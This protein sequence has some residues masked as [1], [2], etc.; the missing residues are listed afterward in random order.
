M[1]QQDKEQLKLEIDHIFE[2]GANEIRIFEMVV[3]F[4][5]SRNGVNKNFVLADVVGMQ[6][7]G[8][9]TLKNKYMLE[10]LEEQLQDYLEQKKAIEAECIQLMK[11]GK[12]WKKLAKKGAGLKMMIEA[13]LLEIKRLS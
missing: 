13:T 10:L 7:Y 9:E 12:E 8:I 11:E 6:A 1:T 2:S 3:N 4:I 5:D